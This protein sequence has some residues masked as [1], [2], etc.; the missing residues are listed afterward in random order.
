MATIKYRDPATEQWVEIPVGGGSSV[1][2]DSALSST[3]ENPVQNKVINSALNGKQPTITSSDPLSA[4]L[5]SG[6]STV[7]TSGSYSD[8]S[9]KPTIPAAANNGTLTIQKNGT[10]VATFGANQSTNA[11]ANITVPTK[12]SELTNDAGYT[13]NT[14]TVTGVK[15]NG[16]TKTPTSGVV[17]IG[18]DII[19]GTTYA[20]NIKYGVVKIWKDSDNYLCIRTDGQ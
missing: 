16:A 7:A 18:S 13:T 8:L 4:S 12:V 11:T 17:D 20:S 5:V 1:T 9:N 14:G 3:S 6:L 10:S 2:V 19:T 15:I